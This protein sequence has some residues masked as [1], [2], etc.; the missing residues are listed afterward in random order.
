VSDLFLGIDIGTSSAKAV[1]TGA[2]GEVVAS[3]A[4]PHRLSIPRQGWAEHDPESIWWDGV[5]ALCRELLR[6]GERVPSAVC[7]SGI[8]PCVLAADEAYRPLRPAILYGIDTRAARE[9]DDL[10]EE[11]GAGAIL[12]RCGSALSTQAVGPKLLWL[13]RNEPEVWNGT[14]RLLMASSFAVAWLTGEY[15]LDHHSASQCDP[16][17]EL[18]RGGWIEEWAE[19]IAPGLELPRLLWPGEQAGVVTAAAAAATGIPSGTPVMAGTIDAWAES[20]AAGVRSA[21]DLMVMYGSTLFL[22]AVTT[23]PLRDESLWSTAGVREDSYSLAAGLATSGTL[24]AWLRDLTG[25]SFED[26]TA[27]ADQAGPGAGGLLALPYFSGERTPILDP[28]A[29]GVL[30]GLTLAHGRGH[31]ARALLEAI[32]FAVRHN[33]ETFENAGATLDRLVAV[34]G[35]TQGAVALQAVSDVTGRPQAVCA[36]GVG[37]CH[38]DAFLAAVGA[39]AAGWDDD[40]SVVDHEVEPRRE[41]AARYEELYGRYRELY[42]ATRDVMHALARIGGE[43]PDQQPQEV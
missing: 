6:N 18:D 2:D 39:G 9:I 32:A 20:L 26:L 19:Q 35:G 10:T 21:G 14:R 17:Y 16:L 41:H 36:S 29:R 5:V 23:E 28:A 38:G 13:R 34:G 12:E 22:I 1:L 43:V 3:A 30:C 25:A 37:A 40:W 27:E 42:P 8:G 31:L 11:L 33:L 7:V 15:V 24:L 4:R